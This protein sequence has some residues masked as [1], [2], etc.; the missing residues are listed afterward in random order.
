MEAKYNS[1]TGLTKLSGTSLLIL[2]VGLLSTWALAFDA[3]AGIDVSMSVPFLLCAVVSA[4]LGSWVVPLLQQLKAGQ[5]IRE[6]GPKAHLKKAGTPTMGGA[7]FVPVAVVIALLA[8]NFESN[9]CAVSVVTFAYMGIGML[10]DWQ[11]LRLKSNKGLSPRMKLILQIAIAVLFCLWAFVTQPASITTVILPLGIVLPL[12]ALFWAVAG[13]AIVAESNSTNIT[14]GVDGLAAGTSAIA[15][16]G[17]G[18][19]VA[20]TS[21]TMAIFC[22]CLSGGCLGFLIHN[23]N[24]ARVF[25][26]DTGSLALGGALA[27]VGILTQ[28]LWALLII[29]GIFCVESLS[30]IAQVS[31]YKATKD[32]NGIG[33][34]LLK[35]AP[36]HHHLE[37]S[38]WSETQ[39]VG[40]FYAIEFVLVTLA[41][42][43]R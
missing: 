29:S 18:L 20:S 11:V 23:R 39:I 25:M 3:I 41:A 26:G 38:G 32:S 30:V 17:L 12:G 5:F 15:L 22:L 28:N 14:D 42:I 36:F 24:P 10:D 1:W 43:A 19:L 16:M 35:M 33:K 13:F 27:A 4:I 40:A 2:L 37:L 8:S 6:D 9:V 31:Y 21:V 7:F 34:R